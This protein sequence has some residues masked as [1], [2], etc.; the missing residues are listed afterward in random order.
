MAQTNHFGSRI[1]QRGIRRTTIELALRHGIRHGEKYVLGKKQI[2]NLMNEFD[3]MRKN[4]CTALDKSGV[5]VVE[6]N[7][8]LVTAYDL[9]SFNSY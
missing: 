1:S 5:V 8:A 6:S 9:D 4:L 7:G 3:Q 2:K